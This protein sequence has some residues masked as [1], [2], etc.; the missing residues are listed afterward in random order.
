M[1]HPNLMRWGASRK[2]TAH[3]VTDSNY[4]C[5][6][7]FAST[8]LAKCRKADKTN[9]RIF[10]KRLQCIEGIAGDAVVIDLDRFSMPNTSNVHRYHVW[11]HEN[12]PVR[13]DLQ[14]AAVET[15]CL[16]DMHVR[17]GNY[18]P[19]DAIR[20]AAERSSGAVKDVPCAFLEQNHDRQKYRILTREEITTLSKHNINSIDSHNR[21]F[22]EKSTTHN[23]AAKQRL[24]GAAWAV[25]CGADTL[26][27]PRYAE[28]RARL[29]MRTI[30]VSAVKQAVAVE[31]L[32][33][34]YGMRV[35]VDYE[36]QDAQSCLFR[37]VSSKGE[38]RSG[39]TP[40]A[41]PPPLYP[42]VQSD[43]EKSLACTDA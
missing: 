40:S 43:T 26:L 4:I 35:G 27:P 33:V 10:S 29:N 24:C 11:K 41:P 42:P 17:R 16:C 2:Y 18:D 13:A 32:C 23:I 21:K 3:D 12:T 25:M 37:L 5:I 19:S 15:L 20:V 28:L 30:A 38:E 9:A 6:V 7:D 36:P 1:S 8:T 31:T 14:S 22:Y 34:D 39:A